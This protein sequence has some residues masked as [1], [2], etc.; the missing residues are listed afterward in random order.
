MPYINIPVKLLLSRRL[1][2][3][4]KSI[5]NKRL[6]ADLSSPGL[7]IHKWAQQQSDGL[8]ITHPLSRKR[9]RNGETAILSFEIEFGEEC[10]LRKAEV[11]IVD[12]GGKNCRNECPLHQLK[13]CQYIIKDESRADCWGI[14]RDTLYLPAKKR[15]RV[16]W[17]IMRKN[18]R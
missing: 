8:I 18:K 7:P 17:S 5:M 14:L 2:W 13:R 10:Y 6:S 1:T 4:N 3:H 9:D 11:V 15:I 12:E 16:R